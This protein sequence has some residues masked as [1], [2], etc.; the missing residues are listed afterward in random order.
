MN[1]VA[2]PSCKIADTNDKY[3]LNLF[4]TPSK[5]KAMLHAYKITHYE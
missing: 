3:L 1:E 5:I 2:S 4:F